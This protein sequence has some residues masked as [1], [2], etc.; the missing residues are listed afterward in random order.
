LLLVKK[1]ELGIKSCHQER[2]NGQTRYI[3]NADYNET[4]LN[5]NGFTHEAD[6]GEH[7]VFSKNSKQCARY[8]K[9]VKKTNYIS[10]Q[11]HIYNT[12]QT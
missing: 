2:L 3:V 6:T 10:F 1:T 8:K 9:Y 11:C 12:W 5:M 4:L 7:D